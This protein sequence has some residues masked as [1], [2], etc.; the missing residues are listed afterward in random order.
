ML[1]VELWQE[2]AH[3]HLDSVDVVLL[4]C[5]SRHFAAVIPRPRNDQR[6]FFDVALDLERFDAAFAHW[7]CTRA[8]LSAYGRHVVCGQMAS[9][10]MTAATAC[11]TT[12]D[13]EVLALYEKLA[14]HDDVPGAM[15]RNVFINALRRG[16]YTLLCKL[17]PTWKLKPTQFCVALFRSLAA[18]GR[19][20]DL[21]GLLAACGWGPDALAPAA[22]PGVIMP[23]VCIA[24]RNQQLGVLCMLGRHYYAAFAS[25]TGRQRQKMRAAF[26]AHGASP[27]MALWL[28]MVYPPTRASLRRERK[29]ACHLVVSYE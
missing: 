24:A 9:R 20:N 2:I 19:A 29:R 23:L 28:E 17:P 6:A 16:F 5:V 15:H 12:T 11:R 1:P 7:A 22:A 25:R 27:E 21:L 10:L 26:A 18:R 4:R 8:A 13:A 3:R 14:A